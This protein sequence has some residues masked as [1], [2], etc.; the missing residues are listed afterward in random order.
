M[1]SPKAARFRKQRWLI[2]L[3]ITYSSGQSF[4]W[5]KPLKLHQTYLRGRLKHIRRTEKIWDIV[6]EIKTSGW[7]CELSHN[8]KTKHP[9]AHQIYLAAPRITNLIS[10]CGSCKL[11]E[12]G[13]RVCVCA[14]VMGRHSW[15][16]LKAH[17]H[18]KKSQRSELRWKYCCGGSDAKN[19]R[20]GC[21]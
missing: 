10:A 8:K 21:N 19:T 7:V 17:W 6:Q 1:S 11:N 20:Q 13:E 14:Y 15:L 3:I 5:I 2:S 9:T 4:L 12:T 18:T 16:E